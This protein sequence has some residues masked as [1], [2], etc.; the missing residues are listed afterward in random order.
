MFQNVFTKFKRHF[1]EKRFLYF[2]LPYLVIGAAWLTFTPDKYH[3]W[4]TYYVF[5]YLFLV[6]IFDIIDWNKFKKHNQNNDF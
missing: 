2:E 5:A 4:I 1:K 6:M 3:F